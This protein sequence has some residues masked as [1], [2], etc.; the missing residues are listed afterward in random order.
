MRD[1]IWTIIA[2]WFLWRIIEAFRSYSPSRKPNSQ[3]NYSNGN[4]SAHTNTTHSASDSRTKKGEL[5]S[6]AGEYVDYED[7][8]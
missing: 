4:T 7:V 3:S 8:K 1:I 2:I 5:R 6:D